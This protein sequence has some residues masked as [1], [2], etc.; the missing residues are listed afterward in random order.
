MITAKTRL[1]IFLLL[2]GSNY[3]IQLVCMSTSKRISSQPVSAVAEKVINTI[4]AIHQL[5][6]EVK[7]FKFGISYD[8][9]MLPESAVQKDGLYGG[10]N[11]GDIIVDGWD[12][13][14]QQVIIIS[15]ALNKYIESSTITQDES[16]IQLS[17]KVDVIYHLLKIVGNAKYVFSSATKEEKKQFHKNA[18]KFALARM[19]LKTLEDLKKQVETSDFKDSDFADGLLELTIKEIHKRKQATL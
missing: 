11:G 19:R 1:H 2:L 7:K 8:E 15:P 4:Y 10:Q 13:M 16:S 18:N 12:D 9:S 3:V 17:T 5:T 6:D 14:I